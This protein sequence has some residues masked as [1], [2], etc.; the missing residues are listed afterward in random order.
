MPI[1]A[2]AAATASLKNKDVVPSRRKIN[3]DIRENV[4]EFL[5]AKNIKYVRSEA[6]HFMIDVKRPGGEVVDAMAKQNV[7]IGRLWPAW[8][9]HVR[10][11]VGTQAEMDRFKTAFAKVMA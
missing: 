8:P 7:M 5:E 1:T 6:N 10:V 2:T 9:T 4:F 11:S 3:K